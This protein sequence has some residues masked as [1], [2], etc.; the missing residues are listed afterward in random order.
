M[1]KTQVV[2]FSKNNYVSLLT[3]NVFVFPEMRSENMAYQNKINKIITFFVRFNCARNRFFLDFFF[4]KF[5]D[6]FFNFYSAF[7]SSLNWT[8]KF[9]I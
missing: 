5:I 8:E 9:I 3:N 7:L 1:K 2:I 6:L 4:W